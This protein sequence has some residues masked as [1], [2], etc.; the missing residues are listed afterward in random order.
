MKKILNSIHKT[1]KESPLQVAALALYLDVE[2][3]TVSKWNSN[4][5]QPS[6]KRLDVI[7]E[8]FE[9]NNVDLVVAKERIATGRAEALQREYKRL[10]KS[11]LPAKIKAIDAKGVER[12]VNNPEFV[13]ALREFRVGVST[14]AWGR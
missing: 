4:T 10:L 1:I 8:I 9:V 13:K 3:S 7:A 12:N 6:F 5:E 11:G 2:A 14:G